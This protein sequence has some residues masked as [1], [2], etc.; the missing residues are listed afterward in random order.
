MVQISERL[1]QASR[2][3]T[4]PKKF[5]P[6]C[7]CGYSYTKLSET[8]YVWWERWARNADYSN[9]SSFRNE[10]AFLFEKCRLPKLELL[11]FEGI[12]C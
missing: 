3:D 12:S 4:G 8:K 1:R 5:R 7:L 11:D 10:K 6:A 9:G 2:V